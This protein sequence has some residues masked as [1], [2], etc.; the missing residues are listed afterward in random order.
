MT[1]NKNTSFNATDFF[2]RHKQE[3]PGY[4]DVEKFAQEANEMQALP[5]VSVELHPL[6]ALAIILVIQAAIA[7]VPELADDGFAK[8]S[9]ASARRLQ[10]NLFNQDSETHKALQFGWNPGAYLATPVV[11]AAM[12][13]D[14]RQKINNESGKSDKDE[15]T[16]DILSGLIKSLKSF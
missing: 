1:T 10:E 16:S 4:P 5:P 9:I 15:T 11:L 3:I 14:I 6:E 2:S 12:L 13:E 8:I 7:N